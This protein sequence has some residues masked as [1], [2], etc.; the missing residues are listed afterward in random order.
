MEPMITPSLLEAVI[1]GCACGLGLLMVIRGLIGAPATEDGAAGQPGALERHVRELRAGASLPKIATAAGAGIAAYLFTSW[2]VAGLLAALAALVLPAY[3]GK[4]TAA[5]K[6][7]ARIEAVAAWTEQLQ[8]T[9]AA[10]AGLEQSIVA[11]AATAPEAI[12]PHALALAGRIKEGVRTPQALTQFADEV[13]D[14]TLDLACLA[15]SAAASGQAAN[16]AELLEQLAATARDQVEL[17]LRTTAARAKVRAQVRAVI[18]IVLGTVA[19]MCI[20]ARSY[21]APYATAAGQLVLLGV[22]GIFG[23]SFWWMG[24]ISKPPA[25]RRLFARHTAK[26]GA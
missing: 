7:L 9:M 18:L 8:G 23:L 13:G 16:L 12:R 1:T 4:D 17:R 26:E 21:L 25:A 6:D 2:P 24:K 22:G 14:E 10:A 15:L 5:A 3:L 20:G 11:A 19:L